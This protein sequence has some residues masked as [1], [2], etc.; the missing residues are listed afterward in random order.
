M[1]AG[2]NGS[3]FVR[4]RL[5]LLRDKYENVFFF[6][7]DESKWGSFREN[8]RIMF[9][10]EMD[11]II[12]TEHFDIII[13]ADEWKSLY[14][15]CVDIH[16]SDHVIDIITLKYNPYW[17]LED[18]VIS[19]Y[20]FVDSLINNKCVFQ[21]NRPIPWYTYS[22]IEYLEELDFS[23][24][25]VFEYGSGFSSFYWAERCKNLISVENDKS[26]AELIKKER[27]SNQEIILSEIK[28]E[29]VE[30]IH[31]HNI[32]YDVI[33]IDGVWRDSCAQHA[34]TCIAQDGM[35]ILDNSERVS[36]SDEYR[37]AVRILES[38]DFIQ[39]DFKGIGAINTYA[40]AT[41][42]FVSRENRYRR[43]NAY[44]P[45]IPIGGIQ[46]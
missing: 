9:P 7:N 4:N 21:Y 19:K 26:W 17:E 11:N 40:W 35:I 39:I 24:K 34:I 2:R 31:S 3:F 42:V 15:Q 14:K 41:S 33:V 13:T 45:S 6:D 8:I 5:A 38:L 20:G 32:K 36:F 25:S 43:K 27:K 28:E 16:I 10:N 37:R 30:A 22:T 18:R 29:Y 12:L 44:S 1:G 23:D 46:E